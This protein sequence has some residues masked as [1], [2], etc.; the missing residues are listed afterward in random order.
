MPMERDKHEEILTQLLN[1]ELEQSTRTELLQSL[2]ADYS[3]VIS[4]HTSLSE[5]VSKLQANNDD[6]IVSNSK[7]FREIGIT[8]NDKQEKEVEQKEFSET[9]TLEELGKGD[10]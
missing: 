3:T 9:V 1:P 8:G 2:R 10:L 5:N 6:L 4:D 7:L